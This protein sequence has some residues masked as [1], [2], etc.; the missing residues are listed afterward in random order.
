[1][2]R[3]IVGFVVTQSVANA[4]LSRCEQP[5]LNQQLPRRSQIQR[6]DIVVIGEHTIDV[7]GIDASAKAP[8]LSSW[9]GILHS[10]ISGKIG[11][12]NLACPEVGIG[13]Y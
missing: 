11:A 7:R 5:V 6:N 3:Q 12:K 10:A 1:M 8:D 13:Y 2:H 4:Q 9:N